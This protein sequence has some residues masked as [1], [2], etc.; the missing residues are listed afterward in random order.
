[1]G[2]GNPAAFIPM[3]ISQDVTFT[4]KYE[5]LEPLTRGRVESFVVL[6]V[7]ANERV[8]AHIFDC[9]E[10]KPQQP[11]VQ[12]V[13][14]SFRAIA[15]APAGR[16]IDTGEYYEGT[17]Y[18]Y[19]VTRLPSDEHLREWV[20]A[21][22]AGQMA[23]VIAEPATAPMPVSEITKAEGP[24]A[25]DQET[26][27]GSDQPQGITQAFEALRLGL[28]PE[29]TAKP[30]AVSA[31]R[32]PAGDAAFGR[33]LRQGT[34]LVE[35]GKSAEEPGEFTKHFLQAVNGNQRPVPSVSSES[36]A[37]GGLVS[38]PTPANVFSNIPAP[39]GTVPD[40][41]SGTQVFDS[42]AASK[43]E[44]RKDTGLVAF[45]CVFPAT[46]VGIER[47]ESRSGPSSGEFTKFYR[48]PFDGD[49]AQGT[50]EIRVPPP[51]PAK[52]S[53]FTQLFGAAG[54]PVSS[55]PSGN[56]GPASDPGSV[57]HILKE[58][59]GQS[60]KSSS[61]VAASTTP[62]P[63]SETY[64]RRSNQGDANEPSFYDSRR[65][66]STDP[67]SSGP[68]LRRDTPAVETKL[69]E[70]FSSEADSAGATRVF[71]SPEPEPT[72]AR[73][74]LPAGNSEYTRIISGGMRSP[75]PAT[76]P[77]MATP[78][79][80]PLPAQ[81]GVPNLPVSLSPAPVPSISVPNGPPIPQPRAPQMTVPPPVAI[82]PVPK[83]PSVGLGSVAPKPTPIP[84]AMIFVFNGLFLLAV[85]LVLYFVLKR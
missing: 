85:A 52:K 51:T 4:E 63:G 28:A 15:P 68:S 76:E 9:P 1:M 65:A 48:G 61:G 55:K 14:E 17:T 11:T 59:G 2:S 45:D 26:L 46:T 3:S 74:T 30:G 56:S 43:S 27:G 24:P 70:G 60:E 64:A 6:N 16:V 66:T 82:P 83:P 18:A 32:P 37:R 19:L 77:V 50:P 13:L 44:P 36:H 69:G 57:T 58:W 73:S 7:A 81:A 31:I 20:K 22:E 10:R 54:A 33:D 38:E 72:P 84:W 53:E 29:P 25:S 41:G 80:Q 75:V 5:I 21:Y 78:P 39:A 49:R 79:G 40:D 42:R 62:G 8:V 71:S 23:G 67:L 47:G 12:W 35:P 34:A